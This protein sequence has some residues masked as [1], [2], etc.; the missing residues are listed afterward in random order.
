MTHPIHDYFLQ[1]SGYVQG[2]LARGGC[3]SPANF[4]SYGTMILSKFPCVFYQSEFESYME[5]KL[6]LAEA[7]LPCHLILATSHFESMNTT[8]VRIKQLEQTF[9]ILNKA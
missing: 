6:I 5:R 2:I 3:M 9:K 1:N 7:L 4:D 8:K